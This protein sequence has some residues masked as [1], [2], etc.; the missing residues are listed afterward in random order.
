MIEQLMIAVMLTPMAA[1]DSEAQTNPQEGWDFT[2]KDFVIAAWNPPA[3]TSAEYEVY[4]EAGFNIVM[5]PRYSLPDRALELAQ[6]HGLKLLVDTYIPNDKPWGET[7]AEY[8]P[9]T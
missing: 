7:A 9:R 8:R 5:S 1:V 2:F 4:R 3:A 6:K